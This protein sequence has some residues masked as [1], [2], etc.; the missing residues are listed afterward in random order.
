MQNIIEKLDSRVPE[1]AVLGSMIIG[2]KCIGKVI[3]ILPSEDCFWYPAHRI[4][5]A[6]ILRRYFTSEKVD[7]LLI[8]DDLERT[9]Q[10]EKIGGFDY[11]QKML[12]NIPSAANAEFYAKAVRKYKKQRD[13]IRAAG[14]IQKVIA[15][16]DEPENQIEQIQQIALG[17]ESDAK[18]EYFP[19]SEYAEKVAM[20]PERETLIKT[21]LLNIDELIGGVS[22]GEIIILAGRPS[23]GKSALALQFALNMAKAGLAVVFFTLEMTY[24]SLIRRALKNHEVDELKKLDIVIHE[25]GQTPE[26]Q[27]AFVKTWK[28]AHKADVVFIDYLQLMTTARKA[29]SRN[30]EITIISRQLKRLAV[31]ERVPVIALSQLN[32]QVENRATHKPRLS[33]LRE[34]GS[35]EQDADIVMLLHREDYYRRSENPN[36]EQDGT[37]EL[38]IAKNRDG[39]TDVAKLVFLDDRVKF[40]DRL[41]HDVFED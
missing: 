16:N 11:L 25:A 29:E 28:Q 36:S 15:D 39:P 1:A 21:G 41:P 22:P 9:G 32:R 40:G 35:I 20:E 4:I 30:Q 27:I 19:F 14:D 26:K 37:T 31:S 5:Y 7:G 18:S 33:D 8:R 17:L 13:I 34:S 23:M 10:L 2:P 12:N 6:L 24:Q 3:G 38:F